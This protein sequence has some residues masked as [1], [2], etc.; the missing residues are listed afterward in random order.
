M[1]DPFPGPHGRAPLKPAR[2]IGLG[3]PFGTDSIGWDLV[4]ELAR[5]N[6]LPPGVAEFSRC[7]R[8]DAVLLE[9]LGSPGLVILIDA[10]RSGRPPGTVRCFAAADVMA[11]TGMIST[12]D[13]GIKS[14]LTL[15][16]AIGGLVA[17]VRV[18]GVEIAPEPGPTGL[19]PRPPA[20]LSDARGG[21]EILS[22][23]KKILMSTVKEH[24]YL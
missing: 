6:E 21:V 10:M 19:R 3:S 13:F 15:A 9:T 8:P 12:H 16:D 11:G 20:A 23:I 4:E 14:A 22:E 17:E 2:V 7:G 24:G 18:L 1:R 5:W